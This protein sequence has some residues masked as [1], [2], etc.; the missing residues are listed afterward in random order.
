[1][2]TWLNRVR[3]ARMARFATMLR[4]R[5]AILQRPVIGQLILETVGIARRQLTLSNWV[6][7]LAPEVSRL[8]GRRFVEPAGPR[9]APPR[10][11]VAKPTDF[12]IAAAVAPVHRTEPQPPAPAE[13]ERWEAE[14][15]EDEGVEIPMAGPAETVAGAVVE[16][17]FPADADLAPVPASQPGELM[18]VP[19]GV[20]APQPIAIAPAPAPA[21]HAAPPVPSGPAA[22]PAEIAPAQPARAEL[23]NADHTR[24]A[25]AAAVLRPAETRPVAPISA[26]GPEPTA[27]ETLQVPV[28]ESIEPSRREAPAAIPESVPPTLATPAVPE[29]GMPSA[30]IPGE[31]TPA[32]TMPAAAI[33][34]A[35][36]PPATIPPAAIPG[37]PISATTI[38]A[39]PIATPAIPA[40]LIPPAEP[41]VA[42]ATSVTVP[43]PLPKTA[44]SEPVAPPAAAAVAPAPETEP[45]LSP[46]PSVPMAAPAAPEPA[47][48]PEPV[49]LEPSVLEPIAAEPMALEPI[50]SEA[51]ASEGP[52]PAP[53]A[54]E[55]LPPTE[56]A[57]EPRPVLTWTPIETR[58][59]RPPAHRREPIAPSVTPTAAGSPPPT[60]RLTAP[61]GLPGV[62]AAAAPVGA[63]AE[64]RPQ[65]SPAEW[66]ARLQQA[67]A[68][69][70]ETPSPARARP[71]AP[72]PPQGQ[73]ISMANR[74][75]LEPMLGIDAGSVRVHQ[76]PDAAQAAASLQ[77]DAL[78]V[79]EDIVL[80]AGRQDTDPKTVGLLAHELL[81]I[82]R[83]RTPRF[84]PPALR[85]TP[86]GTGPGQ[87][88]FRPP[89][90]AS[91]GV[92]PPRRAGEPVPSVAHA[93]EEEAMALVVE[94]A[95]IATS[96]DRARG[97]TTPG[98]RPS[99]SSAP[100][101]MPETPIAP[102]AGSPGPVPTDAETPPWGT[103]PAPWEPLPD[104][105][106]GQSEVSGGA[107][108]REAAPSDPR[109]TPWPVT[110]TPPIQRA[111][112]ERHQ[113]EQASKPHGPEP[114]HEAA[115]KVDLDALAKQVYTVLKRRLAGERRR[116]L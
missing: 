75:V 60:E 32:P 8:A 42:S 82:A 23:P 114:G 59:A 37:E 115:A 46:A 107:L 61:A 105:P 79:G 25:A 24:P 71:L 72:A 40:A 51:A 88:P 9:T 14:T 12:A 101:A 29:A 48:A 99:S 13:L 11:P 62:A 38:P 20:P 47:I 83:Q 112:E 91:T 28:A 102:R 80:G 26:R 110:T 100:S 85:G 95:A 69:K 94:A 39:P 43:T 54:T 64:E 19:A 27:L 106:N 34:A 30:V 81:H 58:Q 103:L 77:A 96:R 70:P 35:A 52:K 50:A 15:S 44:P 90:R 10:W 57:Q 93:A 73:P 55:E 41:P 2:L 45:A 97:P 36:I 113:G 56:P 78:A 89:F 84:V 98:P 18:P 67:Y 76:G 63:P 86:R 104:E 108:H 22:R 68:R 7:R 111:G 49:A 116:A 21:E 3:A 66:L 74:A 16:P 17:L 1:M 33:P 92:T 109:A 87:P 31:P 4:R 6:P 5:H 65:A 53:A